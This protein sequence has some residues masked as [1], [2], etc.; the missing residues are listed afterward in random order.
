MFSVN[1]TKTF[2]DMKQMERINER[3]NF[4]MARKLGKLEFFRLFT[5]IS[6]VNFD[7]IMSFGWPSFENFCNAVN[8]SLIHI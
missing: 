3:E 5:L 1:V 6:L 8:L 7:M 4:Q 2:T